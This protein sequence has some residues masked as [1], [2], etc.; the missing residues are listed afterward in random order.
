MVVFGMVAPFIAAYLTQTSF[1]GCAS[2]TEIKSGTY[3]L[4]ESSEILDGL[5]FEFGITN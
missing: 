1:F 5:Y 3:W 4:A 2:S